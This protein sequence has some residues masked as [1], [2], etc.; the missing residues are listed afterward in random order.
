MQGG[1]DPDNRRDF[2]GGFPGDSNNAFIQSGRT[3]EQQ[4]VFAL[5]QQLL[6]L[7]RQHLAL[8]TGSHW[9][10]FVDDASYVFI[11]QA[12]TDRV[13]VA[14]NNGDSS[15]SLKLQGDKFPLRTVNTFQAVLGEARATRNG[16]EVSLD[17]P[18]HSVTL[19][20][21]K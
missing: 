16:D 18:P 4:D 17:I 2:P 6:T 3:P 14:F 20:L 15:R 21:A 12:A 1:A 11:R 19:M 10:L 13:L 9:N 8:T 5:V 7:R